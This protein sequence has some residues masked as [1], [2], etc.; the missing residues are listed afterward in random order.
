LGVSL[1]KKKIMQKSNVIITGADGFLGKHL[2]QALEEQVLCRIFKFE[3]HR[4]NLLK[5][6]SLKSLLTGAKV[7]IHLAG[8]NRDTNSNLLTVNTLGTV[9]LIQAMSNYCPR[10]KLIFASSVQVNWPESFYGLT[11]KLAEEAIEYYCRQ[12][13]ITAVI[14]RV[15]N[16]YG[17]DGKPFYNSTIATFT[18]LLK[19]NKPI[20]VRG[21]GSQT[22][23]FIYVTDVVRSIILALKYQP[24]QA[25]EIFDI[26]SGKEVTIRRVVETLKR[27]SGRQI[28]IDYHKEKEVEEAHP[29][30]QNKKVQ[31]LLGWKPEV[32][33]NHGLRKVMGEEIYET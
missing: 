28:K 26:C 16:I 17:P 21:D 18:Y 10:A 7:V 6:K 31:E 14:L 11:K 19:Q 29:I 15:T 9:G 24:K 13:L 20:T 27:I 25:F 32:G 2:C 3:R 8:A 4:H 33:L 30:S 22:R 1:R 12:K 5:P 23:D